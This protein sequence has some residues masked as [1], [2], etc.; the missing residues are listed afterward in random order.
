[1]LKSK[2]VKNMSYGTESDKVYFKKQIDY[3][4]N[5]NLFYP[6]CTVDGYAGGIVAIFRYDLT[7][8]CLSIDIR[9]LIAKDGHIR[10]II[11]ICSPHIY[12]ETSYHIA[13]KEVKKLLAKM[14][15]LK[16]HEKVCV[17][18]I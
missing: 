2:E 1:M 12:R 6:V 18:S 14:L 3:A 9:I 13:D 4:L 17:E 10:G 16:A 8:Q 11:A 7:E 15:V 5:K